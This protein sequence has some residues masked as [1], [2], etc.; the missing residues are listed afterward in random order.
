MSLSP[1]IHLRKNVLIGGLRVFF[2]YEVPVFE[3]WQQAFEEFKL[4]V[5]ELATGLLQMIKE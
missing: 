1:S 3:Q 2:E 4:K 5:R